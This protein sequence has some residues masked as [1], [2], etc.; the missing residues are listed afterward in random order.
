MDYKYGESNMKASVME[1]LA[2]HYVVPIY[3]CWR[4]YSVE[5]GL[6]CVRR[7]P[8]RPSVRVLRKMKR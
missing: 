7:Q 6:L 2:E 5:F 8:V 4:E 3:A 1:E